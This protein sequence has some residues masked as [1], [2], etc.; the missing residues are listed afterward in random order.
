VVGDGLAVVRAT[1]WNVFDKELD[2]PVT[3]GL[4]VEEVVVD[5]VVRLDVRREAEDVNVCD[6]L[7]DKGADDTTAEEVLTWEVDVVAL[8]GVVLVV[9]AVILAVLALGV[10]VVEELAVVTS[11]S[12][13]T[14]HARSWRSAGRRRNSECI[15]SL[16]GGYCIYLVGALNDYNWR[17]VRNVCGRLEEKDPVTMPALE[18][19]PK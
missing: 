2:N 11:A 19:G 17:L 1:D 7:D 5:A 3:V 4:C 15:G 14:Y 18:E 8:A 6:E 10:W 9:V 16:Q 12:R 13:F